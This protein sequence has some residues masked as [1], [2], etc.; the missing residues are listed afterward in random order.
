[1]KRC[2]LY[3]RVSTERPSEAATLKIGSEVIR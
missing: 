2:G 3:I 1:M